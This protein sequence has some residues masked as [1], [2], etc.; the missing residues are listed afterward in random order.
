MTFAL[1]GDANDYLG[2]GLSGGKIIV[3]PPA[4]STFVPEENIIIGNVGALRRNQRRGVH[5]RHGRRA[6]RRAQQ[7][8]RA[9]VEARGR[10]RL[11]VHDRRSRRRA[12]ADR[13]ATSPPACPAASPTCSTRRATFAARV[14]LQMVE[15]EA[16]E[17]PAEIAKVRG[18]IERHSRAH[19]QRARPS[20]C[21][22]HW[23]C[24]LPKFVCSHAEGLQARAG[25]ARHARTSRA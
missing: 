9:V 24:M 4:G 8:R 13:A 6:L 12:W 21:S 14:N 16:L 20:T 2:K 17:D 11:R 10:P 22:T 19:R 3:F 7:R 1:E 23:E 15:L 5:P 18:M 25:I